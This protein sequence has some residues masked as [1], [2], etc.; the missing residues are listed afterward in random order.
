MTYSTVLAICTIS[1]D[2]TEKGTT[3]ITWRRDLSKKKQETRFRTMWQLRDR[4]R[5]AACSSAISFRLSWNTD[6]LD[7][8]NN[9]LSRLDMAHSN[10]ANP[11]SL[12]MTINSIKRFFPICI[13]AE[14]TT[15]QGEPKH[16]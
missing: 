14:S 1:Q 12:I 8:Q 5:D 3:A 4:C 6:I 15:M 13:I 11:V 10:A 9:H 2:V 7:K 16:D